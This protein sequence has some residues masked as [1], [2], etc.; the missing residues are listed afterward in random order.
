MMATFA[1]LTGQKVDYT[2]GI[3][4]LPELT[5]RSEVQTKR[6]YIYFE[7]PEKGG[8]VAI[9]MGNWKGVR[10]NVK[11]N[12]NAPWQVF[13]LK[14]DSAETTDV[15]ND[16]PELVKAFDG[17]QKKEHQHAHIRE[18]EFI[19]PKFGITSQ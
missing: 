14:T 15:A 2:D 1:D 7:Y 12:R 8:Q 9:R 4:L 13:N 18:W 5:G 10:T 6:S 3:S 17:I 19:D 11:K 16:H